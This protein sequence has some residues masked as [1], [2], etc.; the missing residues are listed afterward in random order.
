MENHDDPIEE[1]K[2]QEG[3]LSHVSSYHCL[4]ILDAGE[5]EKNQNS[6]WW[7]VALLYQV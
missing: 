3:Q 2:C 4:P 5:V 6:G 1:E 7:N